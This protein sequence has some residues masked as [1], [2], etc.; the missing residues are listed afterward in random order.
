LTIGPYICSVVIAYVLGSTPSGYLAG[1]AR[2]VDVRTMGSGNIGATNVFRVLGR[3]AGIA[4]LTADALKGFVAT[5]FAP[6]VALHFFAASGARRENLAVAAGVAAILGHNYTCWLRFK[7]GKGIATSA[8]VVLAWVPEACVT[9]VCLWCLGLAA[10]RY[11]SVA[12]IAAALVLPFAVW[13]WNGSPTMTYVMSAL[14]LLAIAKH[15][16]NIQRLL[17][18]TE[19]RIGK[20]KN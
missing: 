2:G 8:G 5:R 7:G 11:V 1:K 12:S 20:T 13:Y 3:T 19:N 15:R 6:L 18:G 17:A 10:T 16:G 4:V 14:S 9:A